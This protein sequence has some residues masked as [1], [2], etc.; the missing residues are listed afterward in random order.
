LI[1]NHVTK[2]GRPRQQGGGGASGTGSWGRGQGRHDWDF[3]DPTAKSWFFHCFHGL[4][5]E[6]DFKELDLKNWIQRTGFK[7]LDIKELDFN[8]LGT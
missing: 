6:L 8:K 2:D 7:E 4:F 5:K 1:F 3:G